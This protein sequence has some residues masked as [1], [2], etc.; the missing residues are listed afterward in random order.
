MGATSAE[1]VKKHLKT[2][3]LVFVGLMFLTAMTVGVSYLHLP[4]AW[5]VVVAMFVASIKASLVAAFFM[6][7]N[8]EKSIIYS[9]LILTLTMFLFLMMIPIFLRMHV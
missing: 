5:A 8:A 1:E 6:H 3:W 4:I 2:Y 9:T 7:L